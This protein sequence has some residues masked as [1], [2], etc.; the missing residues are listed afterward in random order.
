MMKSFVWMY[1]YEVLL[2]RAGSYLHMAPEVMLGHRYNEKVKP[3]NL[4]RL[5]VVIEQFL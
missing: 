5:Q 2:C 4:E 1:F 3:L